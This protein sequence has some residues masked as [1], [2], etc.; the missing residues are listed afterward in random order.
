MA[1][2]LRVLVA[3]DCSIAEGETR[4]CDSGSFTI[5]RGMEN[6][7]V[8]LDP[9]RHLSKQ[10]CRIELRGRTYFVT[11]TSTNGVYVAGSA[12]PIGRGNAQPVNDGDVINLGPCSLRLEIA[13]AVKLQP[14]ATVAAPTD[15][16][17]EHDPGHFGAKAGFGAGVTTLPAAA[18]I[19]QILPGDRVAEQ[20]L[21]DMLGELQ[22][23][24][25]KPAH[26]FGTETALHG[27]YASTNA[28]FRPPEIRPPVIPNDWHSQDA[29]AAS[30]L[31]EEPVAPP[32]S[33]AVIAE[34]RNRPI[35]EV[36]AS[37]PA[38]PPVAQTQPAATQPQNQ[39]Q[40]QAPAPAPAQPIPND[41]LQAFLAGVGLPVDVVDPAEAPAMMHKM[42]LAFREAVGGLRELLELRAFLKSEFR[43]EH[44]LLRAKENNPLK[45][46]ANLDGTLAVLI[47]RRVTGFMEAPEAVRESLRDI[48]AHEVALI[49]GMKTVIGDV[50]D[51]LSPET[52]KG[53]VGSTMLQ[54][55]YKAR[56]WERYEQVHQRLIGEQSSGPPLGSQFSTAYTKQFRNI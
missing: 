1:L 17:A 48:K 6:D 36:E 24:E 42:G 47:G 32:S 39:N 10:H 28:Y 37:A 27:Q 45:F 55:S 35:R 8:V 21:G 15:S 5:G 34:L 13:S 31:L 46:S 29:D 41:V 54:Q 33:A 19:A 52:V 16:A 56:C 30:A 2:V 38:A 3:G 4:I 7:W 25:Y 22:D 18:S 44:T 9:Q 53:G 50:L 11:D 40:N 14:V 26:G 51:Q 43:I 12:T 23:T 49:S 20:Q